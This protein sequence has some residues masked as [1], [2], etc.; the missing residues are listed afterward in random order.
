MHL[1]DRKGY[2]LVA[3]NS[4]GNNI[5]FVRNELLN[6]VV[7]PRDVTECFVHGKFRESR[8]VNGKLAFLNIQ[9]EME[10]ISTLP[11]VDVSTDF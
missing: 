7:T 10:L 9:E 5:F 3:G 8:D 11:L 1:A 2:S 6:D 4:N